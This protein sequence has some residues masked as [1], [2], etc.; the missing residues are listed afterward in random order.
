MGELLTPTHLLIVT[1]VAS[2]LF[3]GKRLPGLGRG[4]G[5]G[6]RG[7]RDGIRGIA[8]EPDVFTTP[9]PVASVAK[10]EGAAN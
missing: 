8:G 10:P 1:V 9:V 6:L 4:L 5:E 7:F 2:V 3:G